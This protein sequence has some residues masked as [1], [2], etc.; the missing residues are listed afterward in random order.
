MKRKDLLKRLV[1]L[2]DAGKVKESDIDGMLNGSLV[3]GKYTYQNGTFRCGGQV[4]SLSPDKITSMGP[5]VSKAP[6]AKVKPPAPKVPLS[7]PR[8]TK[9]DKNA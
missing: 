8:M 3:N 6:P 7:K 4:Q 1:V 9:T 2:L 5:S